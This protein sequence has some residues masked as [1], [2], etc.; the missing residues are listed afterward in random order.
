MPSLNSLPLELLTRIASDLCIH[1][2]STPPDL[3]TSTCFSVSANCDCSYA[4]AVNL[5]LQSRAL[6]NLCLASRRMHAAAEQILY[7]RPNTHKWWLLVAALLSR[8]ELAQCVRELFLPRHEYD[9]GEERGV[10]REVEG[11]YKSLYAAWL[12]RDYERQGIFPDRGNEQREARAREAAVVEAVREFAAEGDTSGG[13]VASVLV[14]LCPRV[15]KMERYVC[16]DA[17]LL[18]SGRDSLLGLRHLELVYWDTEGGIG[19]STVAEITAAA[20]NLEVFRGLAVVGEAYPTG[21]DPTA[22]LELR[23]GELRDLELRAS[24]LNE[25]ALEVLLKAC[26]KLEFFD[27]EIGCM[28]RGTEQFSPTQAADLFDKYGGSSL[29]QV[30]VDYNLSSDSGTDWVFGELEEWPQGEGKRA[31]D[32]FREKGIWFEIVG[33]TVNTDEDD[34]EDGVEG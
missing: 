9:E 11:Y 30:V 25:G 18:Y 21:E 3:C 29:R 32:R 2:T 23:M 26:P 34:V 24:V 8:P 6:L 28:Q 12:G 27:F 17:S 5:R 7:H 13:E 20:P 22:G 10:P 31:A 16:W 19:L 4:N 14:S 15:E 33:C 1:C